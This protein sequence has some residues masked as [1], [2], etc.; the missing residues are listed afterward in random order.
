M[1]A[2]KFA[3]EFAATSVIAGIL[4]AIAMESVMYLITRANWARA[5]MVVA[6]GSLVTRTREHAFRTGAIVHAIA[7]VSFAALYNLA[8]LHFGLN[9]WPASFFTGIG[10]GVVHGMV[11]SLTLVWVVSERHP[12]VEFQE[13]GFAVGLAHLAGHIAYGAAVGLVIG[14]ASA[15]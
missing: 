9:R 12:L 2:E 13:T 6:L 5:N 8:M 1:N 15:V 11:V 3:A 4:G 10:F 7:A 14:V